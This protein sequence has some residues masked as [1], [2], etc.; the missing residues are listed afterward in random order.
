MG[1]SLE[2]KK[3]LLRKLLIQKSEAGRSKN[4]LSYGQR[5]IWFL[6]NTDKTKNTDY[7]TGFAVKMI[8]H[9][10]VELLKEC[11]IELCDRHDTLRSVFKEDPE[12][13]YWEVSQAKILIEQVSAQGLDAKELSALINSKHKVVFD[14]ENGPIVRP[15]IFHV[16]ENSHIFLFS[17]HHIAF[18]EWSS[19]ILIMELISLY[20]NRQASEHFKLPSIHKSYI[21]FI[22]FEG[23]LVKSSGLDK[24]WKEYLGNH[25]QL[26]L[27]LNGDK[28]LVLNAKPNSCGTTLSWPIASELLSKARGLCL[29][30]GTTI[31]NLMISV[32]QLVLY[33]YSN[34]DKFFIGT[35]VAG[36]NNAEF[37]DT[38]GYFVNMLPLKCSIN[39]EETFIAFLQSNFEANNQALLHQEYPFKLM[40]ESCYKK[41]SLNSHP[42]FNVAFTYYNQRTL[43]KEIRSAVKK[44]A[45]LNFEEYEVNSQEAAFDITLEIKE[46]SDAALMKV[47]YKSSKFSEFFITQFSGYYQK[48]LKAIISNPNLPIRELLADNSVEGYSVSDQRHLF[49]NHSK[50]I[51]QEFKDQVK[52]NKGGCALKYND[53]TKTYDEL[54]TE[55]KIIASHLKPL[56]TKE[57]ENIGLT[58]DSS[59]SLIHGIF[60][61]LGLGASYVPIKPELPDNR[62]NYLLE[63][64]G[65]NI[66]LTDKSN[67]ETTLKRVSNKKV[68]CIEDLLIQNEI[69]SIDTLQEENAQLENVAYIMYTSGSTGNPKGV[70]IRQK[71]VLNLVKSSNYISIHSNDQVPQL[72]N[73]SFDG[74]VFDIFGALLNGATLHLLSKET[75]LS[76]DGLLQYIRDNRINKGFFTTALFN[77]FIAYNASQFLSSFDKLLFGGEQLS[78]SHVKIALQHVKNKDVLVHVYGPTESTTFATFHPISSIDENAKSLPI[79]KALSGTCITI[80]NTNKELVPKCVVGEIHISGV[81]LAKGGYLNMP[82]ET[83]AVFVSDPQNESDILYAT[84]DFGMMLP[85]GNILFTGRK[86]HQVKLRG[87]RIEL[88]EIESALYHTGQIKKAVALVKNFHTEKKMLLAV[89][90]PLVPGITEENIKGQIAGFLPDFMMPNKIFVVEELPL[91]QNGKIDRNILEGK[92]SSLLTN[93]SSDKAYPVSQMELKIADIW[94]EVLQ[95]ADIG[96]CDDFFDLGGD[97]LLAMRILSRIKQKYNIEISAKVLFENSTLETLCRQIEKSEA[98]PTQNKEPNKIKRTNRDQYLLK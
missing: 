49:Q 44:N 92:I 66:I 33:K 31:F 37:H 83:A 64:A 38:V 54:Y 30:N 75:V 46:L 52:N 8:G 24:F 56:L 27:E 16:S 51:I 55:V 79:G 80:R 65:I 4:Q 63:D 14:L 20:N 78:T 48:I 13:D 10:D 60:S 42:F 90:E 12:G 35:P 88:G 39:R 41:R 86:D 69:I 36:R 93:T 57:N 15:V 22:Y 74:S 11:V 40:V 61:I 59:F 43:Q 84:G 21:D 98:H 19:R 58:V 18:D 62:Y 29:T 81:G 91:N 89:V 50:S 95:V 97:S 23:K 25:E 47:K 82:S 7:N 34:K 17:V 94:Q 53:Q 70:P 72:S 5:S 77:N 67:Y 73:Y 9:L 76:A 45:A 68:I 85:D 28:E 26:F 71:S 32:F 96:L 87:F 2:D 1:T 6:Q 3:E